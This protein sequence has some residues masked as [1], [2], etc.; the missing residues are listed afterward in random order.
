[1]RHLPLAVFLNITILL[2]SALAGGCTSHFSTKEETPSVL[3]EMPVV[4]A[5]ARPIES[6]TPEPTTSLPILSVKVDSPLQT[7]R[8]VGG[9]NFIHRFGGV[10][11][12]FDPVSRLN[13][14]TLQPR[15]ARVAIDLDEWEPVNDNEDP[16]D[17]YDDGFLDNE[18]SHVHATFQFMQEVYPQGVEIIASV[19]RVPDWMVENP[20]NESQRI[21]PRERYPEVIES[22]A[23]WLMRARDEYH[24]KVSY[25]SF[26]EANLGINVL[27]SPEDA[28]EMIREGGERFKELGLE[29]RWLLGDTSNMG[30]NISYASQIWD[31]VDIRGYLGPL[32]FH[33][34]DAQASDDVLLGIGAFA[35]KNGLDVWCTEGG[36]DA[37][38]WQHPDRFPGYTHALNLAAIYARVLKMTRASRVL[39]WQ[40]AGRDYSL[41]DGQ[42]PYPSLQF[43]D[44]FKRQFPEGSQVVETSPD[45]SAIK[46]VA[47]R[48]GEAVA[49]LLVNVSLGEDV[50]V[51]GLQDGT[52]SV[53]W[54]SAKEPEVKVSQLQFE[55][56]R[57]KVHLEGFSITFLTNRSR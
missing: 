55:G 11:G 20:E 57:A 47:A 19:W 44:E 26:N 25:L 22:L 38:L 53:V 6:P 49:V 28:I 3:T 24:V 50:W 40:M 17:F 7:I 13:W 52:Y 8:E 35:D 5:T 15:A 14:N 27:L 4:G 41:N 29:T 34:W 45:R 33:S 37:Q 1:M 32:A 12:G 42:K 54:S 43:L 51:E 16:N 23:A 9:G 18:G 21:I 36:W 30:E 48:K 31:A 56:K 10:T 2:G 39:Y 46:F